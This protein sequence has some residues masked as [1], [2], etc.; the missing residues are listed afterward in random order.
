MPEWPH[1]I[2]SDDPDEPWNTLRALLVAYELGINHVT[3]MA[4][5]LK[6][7]RDRA[8]VE[9]IRRQEAGRKALSDSLAERGRERARAGATTAAADPRFRSSERH[10]HAVEVSGSDQIEEATDP[11]RGSTEPSPA[12]RA[13]PGSAPSTGSGQ[14]AAS[15]TR[16]SRW[17]RSHPPGTPNRP[18]T[19]P[20]FTGSAGSETHYGHDDQALASDVEFQRRLRMMKAEQRVVGTGAKPKPS[21]PPLRLDE[22]IERSGPFFAGH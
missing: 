13:Q 11:P 18:A 4:R 6:D 9:D 19:T 8:E 7:E 22:V 17:T 20:P 12:A 5:A 1:P 21:P 10:L 16:D 15:S 14:E 2:G 3:T